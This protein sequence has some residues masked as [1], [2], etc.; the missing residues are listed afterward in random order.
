VIH[1][2]KSFPYRFAEGILRP[3]FMVL[4][5]RDWRGAEH[6][7]LDRGFVACSNHMS[8]A[9][10]ITVA[11]FLNDNGCPPRILAKESL[12]HLPVV[13]PVM[14]GAGQIP[15]R[16]ATAD[17]GKALSA[18]VE[19]VE[20]GEC[21]VVFPEGTLTRD[22]RLWPMNGKTGAARIALM[23]DCPVIPLAQWGAQDILAPYGKVPHLL[24]R[25]DSH[26]WA[27]PPVDLADLRTG[28]TDAA[29]LRLATERILED[30]TTMLEQ[31]RGEKRPEQR[32]DPRR[33]SGPAESP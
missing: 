17:A 24:G 13:G 31:I 19:A 26:V 21:V 22:P 29:T 12:F 23:A 32:Y 11:H 16:R 27:G 18:A 4:T 6:L 33:P 5:R 10:T 15:V 3:A 2:S 28:A 7:P 20:Q 8:Y 14:R 9:D 1:R 30:I 25:K